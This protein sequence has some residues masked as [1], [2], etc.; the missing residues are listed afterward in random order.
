MKQI[1]FAA[2][3][4]IAAVV[5][6]CANDNSL[7]VKGHLNSVGDTLLV[8]TE[9]NEKNP[10]T[11]IVK[12]GAFEFSCP[13]NRPQM[14]Y[15][16]APQVMRGMQGIHLAVVGV[17]G[18]TLEI[19]NDLNMGYE[20]G[21]SEFYQ[22]F[23][24][25][26]VAM[27]AVQKKQRALTQRCI[28]MART[29]TPQDSVTA[30]FERENAPLQQQMEQTLMNF[31]KEH[32]Q[33]EV[34]AAVV[35]FLPPS[36]M[37]EGAALLAPSVK[38]GRMK[39][40]Y[41]R[42]IDD[43]EAQQKDEQKSAELQA[44]G[45]VAPEIALKDING[46]PLK[47]S[48]LKGKYVVLDFWGSWCT[49]CIK[50]FPKMKEYYNRYKGKMEILGIDCDDTYDNWKAAIEKHKLPWLHVYNPKESPV[51]GDYGVNGFPTKIVID[52]EGKIAHA[53][54]GE[55]PSFYTYLDKLFAGK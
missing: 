13:L 5:A 35:P 51:L 45:R 34:A 48:S 36:K 7:H 1:G 53:V 6:G 8:I 12:D 26:E 44:V 20:V 19:R 54:T 37:R 40:Y 15:M 46:R 14:I 17:P 23:H 24:K 50:G 25:A 16:V 55:D 3:I 30:I 2:L 27:E 10:Q 18:E 43:Y 33:S 38:N 52:P 21:G 9:E 29:G 39:T 32:A 42:A 22:E 11:V 4:L 47:L 28:D 41:Q 31:I 49:W